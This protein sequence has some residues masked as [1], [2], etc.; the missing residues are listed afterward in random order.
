M[1][2][3]MESRKKIK[4]RRRRRKKKKQRCQ[5]PVRV[6]LSKPSGL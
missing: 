6:S 1:G 2:N 3:L 5:L 4:R